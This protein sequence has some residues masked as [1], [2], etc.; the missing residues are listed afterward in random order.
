[1]AHSKNAPCYAS[2]WMRRFLKLGAAATIAVWFLLAVFAVLVVFRLAIGEMFG[3]ALLLVFGALLVCAAILVFCGFASKCPSCSNLALVN[4]WMAAH[5]Q[6]RQTPILGYKVLVIDIL[7]KG[8]Y[9]CFHCG[10]CISLKDP[11][12]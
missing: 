10:Q 7:V 5:P 12:W 1:M 6:A 11:G 4:S 3:V 9:R 8:R 2:V